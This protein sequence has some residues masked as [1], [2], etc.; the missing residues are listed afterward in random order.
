VTLAAPSERRASLAVALAAL[1]AF[2][3]LLALVPPF[4]RSF[5]ETKYLGI[6]YNMF[7][8]E[9]PRTVFG[10]WFTPHSPLWPVLIVAPD[11]WFGID[12][13]DWGHLINA[14]SGVAILGAVVLLGWRVRP[15]VGALA[16]VGYL[17]VPYL[18]DLTRTA[19]L[20]VPTAAIVLAYVVVGIDA[21]RRGSVGRGSVAG[22]IL[23]VG[24]LVKEIALPFAPVP[25]LVGI[26][27]GRPWA[28]TA[29]VAA[30]TVAVAAIGTSW[31]FVMFADHTRTVYR[32]GASSGLLVPIYVG[33]A[34]IVIAGFA[35]PWLAS[36]PRT[37]ALVERGRQRVP[38]FLDRHARAIVGWGLAFA[39]F[40]AF[41][42]F[43]DGNVELKGNGLFQPDQYAL[44]IRTWLPNSTLLL[45]AGIGA[46]GVALSFVA[47]RSATPRQREQIDAL[48]LT[49]LCSAPLILL[50]I[51]VGE[52]PRN[53]LAQIGVLAVLSATGWLWVAGLVLPRVRSPLAAGLVALA[54]AAAVGYVARVIKVETVIGLGVGAA[55]GILIGFGLVRANAPRPA[56]EAERRLGPGILSSILAASL[57]IATALIG[58]HALGY[59]ASA[60]GSARETAVATAA[61]WIR[62]NVA[63]GSAI[64]FGSFLG[65]ET[66]VE[67]PPRDY[68][69][70]QLHQALA[71]V[72][73]AAP[74]ALA[75]TEQP[76]IDDWIALE[77]SRRET[78]F[79]VFRA[80]VFA[81]QVRR[82][83]ISI[84]VYHTGP[85]TSVP[86][87]LGALTPEHGF[88]ELANWSYP[89][90]GETAGATTTA[91][92]VFAVDQDRV[93]FEGSPMFASS[94]A[95]ARFVT[96]LEREEVSAATAA[97]L[98]ER[99]ALWPASASP[100][101]LL[102]R[103]AALAG[104]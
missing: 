21:V 23:A 5:D 59:R 29:R 104:E 60:S 102:D 92:H 49:I 55:I 52:P 11:V 20:D 100:G 37:I 69:M 95:L 75:M 31:W 89:A 16:A 26:I 38:P 47:R 78:E 13:F 80:S 65:Y 63:P 70:V 30:A 54:F 10:A 103:L 34:A 94:G 2:A 3:I 58:S 67:L 71:V 22:A 48:Y 41:T 81:E 27:G 17:A 42:I 33:V 24:F 74:L 56:A 88:T 51:A 82:S 90:P 19:R 1:A 6:G 25:F 44:Y 18:H 96:V 61:G 7:A 15:A 64:G 98:V 53:Y 12:P 93:G 45:A 32:L 35:A 66:A 97:N 77:N 68:D 72:D 4:F 62:E 101:D 28:T 40:L 14:A 76:P 43:F 73:P 83:G 9:G 99:I 85:I 57:V 87:L 86:A 79:Y 91:T 36:R 50:V 39:W 8:G 46:L 84:Y